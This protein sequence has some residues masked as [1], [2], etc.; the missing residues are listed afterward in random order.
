[1]QDLSWPEDG[2]CTLSTTT[3]KGSVGID[4]II[5]GIYE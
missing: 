1:M 3:G 5:D 2:I 4:V